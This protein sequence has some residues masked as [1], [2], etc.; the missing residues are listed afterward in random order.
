MARVSPYRDERLALARHLLTTQPGITPYEISQACLKQYGSKLGHN[1]C[2]RIKAELNLP[3]SASPRVVTPVT[4]PPEMTE[5]SAETP[6]TSV[7]LVLAHS[8]LNGTAEHLKHV[9]NWM[10][11]MGA[12]QLRLTPDGKVAV[13]AWQHFDLGDTHE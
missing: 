2:L 10:Q 12:E 11:Q 4:L 7:N 3:A 8:P 6:P 1:D 5:A 13:L 9:Q